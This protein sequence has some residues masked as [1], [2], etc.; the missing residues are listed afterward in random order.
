M[1]AVTRLYVGSD[2]SSYVDIPTLEIDHFEE[3]P[4]EVRASTAGLRAS[5]TLNVRPGARVVPEAVDLN[6][7]G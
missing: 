3:A 7:M 6:Q 2:R 4:P 1:G 5:G